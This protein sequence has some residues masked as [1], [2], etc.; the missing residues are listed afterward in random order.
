MPSNVPNYFCDMSHK[1]RLLDQVREAIRVRHYSYR[2]EQQYVAWIR[3]YIL[4]HDRRHPLEMGGPEVER[5]LSHLATERRVASATQAQA[6][7]AVLFLYKCVLNV[8]LPW[9]GNVIRATRPKRLPVVL[10]RTEVRRVL[11]SL[12]GQLLL[13]VSVL[14][15]S[16]LRLLEALRLRFKDVDL[17]R[18]TLIVRDGKGAKDRTT[19]LP[20]SLCDPMRKQLK[21]VRAAHDD[22]KRHG[23]AGVELPYA[24]QR[25]YPR[26]HLE[27]GWQYV[28][29]NSR[30][31]RDPR[32]GAWRRHHVLLKTVQ[33]RVKQAVQAAG[34]EKPASCHTFRHCF[35]TH[36]I[37]SGADIRT[38]QELMGH[39]SVKTTQIYTHVLNRGGIAVRSP[40]D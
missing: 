40:L 19:V 13:I 4:F 22:A 17:E 32:T 18:R 3:R 14:Y 9:L 5:F 1:Q 21:A 8:D 35:A 36:L 37:E 7:A 15:G 11:A 26:A 10:S 39:A 6:L 30:P 29:P 28:F 24:L 31:S 25:K 16:G 34:I 33:R 27:L 23:F 12:D 20:D 38:V 2:T